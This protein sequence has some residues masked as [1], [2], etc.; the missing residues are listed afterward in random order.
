MPKAIFTFRTVKS[1]TVVARSVTMPSRRTRAASSV[2]FKR[3]VTCCA[4]LMRYP[5]IRQI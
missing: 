4:G 1:P 5:K 3:S 2:I